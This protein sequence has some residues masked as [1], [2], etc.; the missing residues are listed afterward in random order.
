MIGILW[1][2]KLLIYSRPQLGF[3]HI[4]RIDRFVRVV[5]EIDSKRAIVLSSQARRPKQIHLELT[6]CRLTKNFA[7][8]FTGAIPP[9]AVG[10]EKFQRTIHRR[11]T[12]EYWR[13]MAWRVFCQVYRANHTEDGK[14]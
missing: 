14:L 12:G 3:Y 10:K 9:V 8:C 13:A 6:L 11:R 5:R 4:A 2:A 7:Q 1:K